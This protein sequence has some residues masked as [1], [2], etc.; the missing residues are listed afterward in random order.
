MSNIQLRIVNEEVVLDN[1]IKLAPVLISSTTDSHFLPNNNLTEA[2]LYSVFPRRVFQYL[3]IGAE[4]LPAGTRFLR[5]DNSTSPYSI[6][7][8]PITKSD[9][10]DG[11]NRNSSCC[12]CFALVSKSITSLG[13]TTPLPSCV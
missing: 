12:F 8:G 2:S 11:S 7:A 5:L 6:A 3:P 1:Y 13:V 4:I 10:P 9:S